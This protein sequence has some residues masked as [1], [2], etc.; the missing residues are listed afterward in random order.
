M[1]GP[2]FEI[3]TNKPKD[4]RFRLKAPNGEIIAQGE[5]YT[6]KHNCEHCIDRIKEYVP[7]ARV[8]DL[9]K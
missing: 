8:V 5:G 2:V 3:Y 9:T 4:Y 7:I 1:A 6:T